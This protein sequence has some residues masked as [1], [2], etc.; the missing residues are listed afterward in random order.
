MTKEDIKNAAE[1]YAKEACRPLWRAGNEQVCMAD[2]ME[3]AEWR[4]NIV[5]HDSTEKPNGKELYLAEFRFFG[6]T[7][8]NLWK[9]PFEPQKEVKDDD[10]I[11]RWAYVKDLIPNTE[12]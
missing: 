1:E 6:K 9:Q 8:Y 10:C 2:F 3:G 5:W 4:I 7:K 11:V 12:E